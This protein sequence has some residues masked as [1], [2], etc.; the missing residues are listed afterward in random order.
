MFTSNEILRTILKTY[1]G[2]IANTEIQGCYPLPQGPK[3]IAANHTVASDALHIPLAI[4]EKLCFL[5][6]ANL[7]QLP[8]LGPLLKL[9]G[10][11]PV[12]PSNRGSGDALTE[13]S[14][15]LAEGKS[16]FIFP[17]GRLVP[18]GSRVR[19]RSG[20]IRLALQTGA[21]II[22]LG[23]YVPPQNVLTMSTHWLGQKRTGLWQFT[24]T[25]HMK[26]G[27]PWRPS[28]ERSAST[29]IHVQTEQL[30]NDIYSLVA[31]LQKEL[32]C[33]SHTS[34]NLILR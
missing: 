28:L 31:E 6:Q 7:F 21:P 32:T 10:H 3:I 18:P 12:K 9:D 14:H 33:A 34:L 23:M 19:A 26:F 13:A 25:C 5:L 30:M 29:N 15:A 1:P 22:P 17:E 11:I 24:G 20:V 8:I 16:L 2:M 4:D 27:T